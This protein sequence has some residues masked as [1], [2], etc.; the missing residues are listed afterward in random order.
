[1]RRVTRISGICCVIFGAC[2]ATLGSWALLGGLSPGGEAIDIRVAIERAELCA[3][4]AAWL[5]LGV[6]VSFST[7]VGGTAW[8]ASER[9]RRPTWSPPPATRPT[10]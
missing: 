1:M 4:I 10:S 9:D 7:A 8:L 5:F 6:V 3:R 2:F